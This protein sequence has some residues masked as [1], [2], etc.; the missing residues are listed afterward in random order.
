MASE[1]DMLARLQQAGFVGGVNQFPSLMGPGEVALALNLEHANGEARTRGGQRVFMLCNPPN[2]ASDPSVSYHDVYRGGVSNHDLGGLDVGDLFYLR[3]RFGQSDLTHG[4]SWKF[5]GMVFLNPATGTPNTSAATITWSFQPNSGNRVTLASRMFDL[6]SG[7]PV[8]TSVFA[9]A[10]AWMILF[11][12]KNAWEH[13]SWWSDDWHDD[14]AVTNDAGANGFW[15]RGAHAVGAALTTGTDVT[16][17]FPIVAL[18]PQA[19]IAFSARSGKK[20]FAVA[21][22]A[23][24]LRYDAS[25]AM[26]RWE[27]YQNVV[28]KTALDGGQSAQLAGGGTATSHVWGPIRTHHALTYSAANFKFVTDEARRAGW[29]ANAHATI[30]N[31]LQ[32][33]IYL[34]NECFVFVPLTNR[35]VLTTREGPISLAPNVHETWQLDGAAVAEQLVFG[36]FPTARSVLGDPRFDTIPMLSDL[37]APHAPRCMALGDG[38]LWAG[39]DNGLLRYSVGVP[40]EDVWPED[41]YTEPIVD[42]SGNGVTAL[43]ALGPAVVAYA[44]NSIWMVEPAGD[45]RLSASQLQAYDARRV[46]VGVGALNQQCVAEVMGSHVFLSRTGLHHF[47]GAEDPVLLSG[48]I[49]PTFD[50]DL[51]Q[52]GLVHASIV[53]VKHK[54]QVWIACA[55]GGSPHNDYVIVWDYRTWSEDSP[56]AFFFLEGINAE[57]WIYD[58]SESRLY[59]VDRYGVVWEQDVGHSDGIAGE[60]G[61]PWRLRTGGLSGPAFERLVAAWAMVDARHYV[62]SPYVL[63]P[64]ADGVVG[65]DHAWD[66]DHPEDREDPTVAAE[67]RWGDDDYTWS[68]GGIAEHPRRKRT[69]IS[70]EATD[71]RDLAL[72]LAS[73]NDEVTGMPSA[74]D[75]VSLIGLT[76][77]AR[78]G[79]TK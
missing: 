75:V 29:T 26:T 24:I 19:A 1:K 37:S 12:S 72:E 18:R 39:Y 41:A 6:T 50:Y 11:S 57:Q 16:Y 47:T 10:D 44:G 48:K 15:V 70:V 59:S 34:P 61:I 25:P 78:I 14:W 27:A 45:L 3:A 4:R 56:G 36:A 60:I 2:V 5:I 54:R 40:Y 32:G 43:R 74:S 66:L 23:P 65:E 69:N 79:S 53:H 63:R 35:L 38:R 52:A 51:N 22:P 31:V 9:P 7:I 20:I 62:G 28:F 64:V 17:G 77:Q 73:S 55:R 42:D 49:Q 71:A 30:P 68:D 46:S 58:E 21:A 8:A 13:G 76:L 67:S 33:R